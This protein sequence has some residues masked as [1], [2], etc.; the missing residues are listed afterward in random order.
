MGETE[1]GEDSDSGSS[2]IVLTATPIVFQMAAHTIFAA[3]ILHPEPRLISTVSR[4]MLRDLFVAVEAL[5]C[6][7]ARTELVASRA[8]SRSCQRLVRDGKRAR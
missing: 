7:S 1:F 5:E 3:G 6:R 4:K 8:L 2:R